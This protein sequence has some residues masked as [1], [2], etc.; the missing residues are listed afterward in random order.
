M[1]Y[2]ELADFLRNDGL[3]NAELTFYTRNSS[4]VVKNTIRFDLSKDDY[5]WS[6]SSQP[7]RMENSYE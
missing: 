7:I 3:T 2:D 5:Q 4:S 1:N 6:I